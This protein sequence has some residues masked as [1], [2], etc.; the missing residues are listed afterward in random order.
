MPD[1]LTI[2]ELSLRTR[3]APSALRYYE[4]LGLIRP[5]RR[6]SGQ[7]RYS[8]STVELVGTILCLRDVG[9]SLAETRT[10]MASRSRSRDA[11]RGMARRKLADLDDRIARAEA[12]RIALRHALRCGR[13]DALAC[14]E[15]AKVLAARLAGVPLADAH[16]H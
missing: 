15:F 11:W 1:L 13:Q 8:E 6:V 16:S 5:A 4:E 2:G 10:L 12:A 7:R 3:L 9:F 14:P